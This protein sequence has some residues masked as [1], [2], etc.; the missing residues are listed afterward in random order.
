MSSTS[1][2]NPPL[3]RVGRAHSEGAKIRPKIPFLS[4]LKADWR[5]NST[6][7]LYIENLLPYPKFGELIKL[8]GDDI[9]SLMKVPETPFSTDADFE[10]LF[11][12]GTRTMPTT[13]CIQKMFSSIFQKEELDNETLCTSVIFLKRFLSKSGYVLQP[14][15][16]KRVILTSVIIAAKIWDDRAVWTA[17]FKNYLPELRV[18]DIN[19]MERLFLSK[20]ACDVYVSAGDYAAYYFGL[21]GRN[22]PSPSKR[23][24]RQQKLSLEDSV[25]DRYHKGGVASPRKELKR[26]SSEGRLFA[27]SSTPLVLS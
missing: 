26:T 9:V 13:H 21:I 24:T 14:R 27:S 20:I 16:F 7:S 12:D 25:I 2:K 18:K 3:V 22:P 10:Y 17:D 15:N 4:T 11:S 19:A 6:S 1:I 8:I 23:F 5:S